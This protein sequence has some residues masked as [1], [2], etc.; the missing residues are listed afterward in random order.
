[1]SDLWRILTLQAGY[2][3]SVVVLGTCVLGVAC[4]VVGALALLR[5]RVLVS[6]ALAHATLPGLAGA[7]MIGAALGLNTRSLPLLLAGAVASGVLGLLTVQWLSRHTRLGED[8]ALA[9]V[10]SVFFGAGAALLSIVQRLST[11]G[12]AGLTRFI[13]GQTAAMSAGDVWLMGG[14][15]AGV[16]LVCVLLFKELRL[17]CFDRGF[18]SAQ[19]WPV[20]ALDLLLLT[21]IT[22]VTV[23]GLQAVGLILVVAMIVTPAAAARFW[24][25]RLGLMVMLSALIGGAAGYLGSALSA[26]APRLPA[27]AVIV[28]TAS[29]L[30]VVSLLCAPRR[31]VLAR[32]LHHA[33]TRA[34]LARE[35]LLRALFE[36]GEGAPAAEVSTNRLRRVRA[37]SGWWGRIAPRMLARRGLVVDRG[38]AL[39][40][41]ADG[42]A[43]A[44][45]ITRVHRLWEAYLI[46]EGGHDPVHADDPADLIE[47]ALDPA[48]VAELERA[49]AAE[50]AV[51]P[52]S[53]H[54]V[55]APGAGRAGP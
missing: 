7:F 8:A 36:A 24:T 17:L 18:A 10:L 21:L 55:R 27:G 29:G 49:V 11:G 43:E 16:L 44:A 22:V 30:F 35:H 39:M 51:M 28:L 13:Y 41:T 45:R 46:R 31:G 53:P 40:L 52:P 6:D 3:T 33:G 19:G 14:A 5:K 26:L 38:G 25:D 32:V 9:V 4:G 2:N 20:T 42:Q 37:R 23:I 1:M 12:Q 50:R 15:A 48:I 47:H 54:A 34:R